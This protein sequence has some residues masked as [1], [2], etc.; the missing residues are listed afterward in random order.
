MSGLILLILVTLQ[1]EP[2]GLQVQRAIQSGNPY[3]ASE[4]MARLGDTKAVA[5]GYT[6]VTRDLYRARRDL[7]A[8]VIVSRQGIEY[9]LIKATE[10]D[11]TDPALASELRGAAKTLAYN[12]AANT[13]PG[14]NEPGIRIT[15][16]DLEAGMDAA[17]LNLRLAIELKR[18][19]DPMFNAHW[20]IGAHELAQGRHTEA[21]ASYE[22]ARKIANEENLRGNAMLA[23]GSIAI[24]KIAGKL[25]VAAGERE[26]SQVKMSLTSGNVPD[27]KFFADQLETA[28]QVF[29][30]K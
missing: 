22:Q 13:W 17:R 23:G 4:I 27:G 14:W 25:D 28:Y 29:I 24:A 30:K 8:F 11:K 26:F 18:G 7:R 19:A 3:G 2:V 21:I 10:A 5:R 12:L 9:L 16:A 20:I 6:E 15:P 1:A